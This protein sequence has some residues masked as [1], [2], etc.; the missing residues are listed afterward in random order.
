MLSHDNLCFSAQVLL[1]EQTKDS[2]SWGPEDR[3]VSYLPLSHIA[4]LVVDV[5]IQLST[6][7]CVYY[8]RPD[9]L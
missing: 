9:A 1:N 3:I 6:G 4:G 2:A 5:V 7:G 8:A